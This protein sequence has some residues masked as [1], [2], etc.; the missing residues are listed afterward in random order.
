M[1][2][3]N[4]YVISI[5]TQSETPCIVRKNTYFY[6]ILVEISLVDNDDLLADSGRMVMQK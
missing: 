1:F 2:L 4:V 6:N 3:S 5:K